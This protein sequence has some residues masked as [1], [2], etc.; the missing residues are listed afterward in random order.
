MTDP[1]ALP[2]DDDPGI[3][4]AAE[5]VAGTWHD[6]TPDKTPDVDAE[7]FARMRRGFGEVAQCATDERDED[8]ATG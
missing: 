7:D 2:G 1:I 5:Q 6:A 4:H 3:E 8:R